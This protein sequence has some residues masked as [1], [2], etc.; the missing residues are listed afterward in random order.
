MP[1]R[2]KQENKV[3]LN[4]NT[5]SSLEAKHSFFHCFRGNV[6]RA[7]LHGG[8]AGLLS[9]IHTHSRSSTVRNATNHFHVKTCTIEFSRIIVACVVCIGRLVFAHI[10]SSRTQ[11]STLYSLFHTFTSP[12]THNLRKT[13]SLHSRRFRRVSIHVNGITASLR[14]FVWLCPTHPPARE[15]QT[16]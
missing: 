4:N 8:L 11:H 15:N 6:S 2:R 7:A 13:V 12:H 1:L 3:G 14:V 10:A 16:V 9:H 5:L